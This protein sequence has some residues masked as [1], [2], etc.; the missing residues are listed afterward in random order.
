MKTL[1]TAVMF[2][3]MAES[4]VLG[5]GEKLPGK[6]EAKEFLNK[7]RELYWSLVLLEYRLTAGPSV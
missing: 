1:L 2:Y 7:Y 6:E 5:S 3:L 4:K